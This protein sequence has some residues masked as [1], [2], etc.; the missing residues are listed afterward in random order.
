MRP[1]EEVCVTEAKAHQLEELL[2]DMGGVL[3]AFS[4]G[5]DSSVLLAAARRALG[6][7]VVAV[8][9][10]SASFPAHDL[11][12]ARTISSKLG[13][14]WITLESGELDDQHYKGNPP[15]RCY[16]CKK[17]LFTRLLDKACRRGPA[18][19]DRRQQHR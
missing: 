6:R 8:T 15:N 13:V 1:I 14:R 16:Y 18:V 12:S 3:V 2:K 5:V 10:T 4:G 7:E 17:S 19:R 11:E 9:G